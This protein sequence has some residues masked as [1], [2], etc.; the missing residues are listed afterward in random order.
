[1]ATVTTPRIRTKKDLQRKFWRNNLTDA[2]YGY[3]WRIYQFDNIP[4]IYHSGWVAGFR[5]DI[6]YAP[7]LDI[8]FAMLINAESNVINQLSHQFWL[9]MTQ[10]LLAKK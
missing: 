2:H 1:L 7:T 10:T 8:G 5:A 6:G 4:I 3:G 9:Q